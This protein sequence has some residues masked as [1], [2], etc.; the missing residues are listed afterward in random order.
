MPDNEPALQFAGPV[1]HWEA[2]PHA[3]D[4]RSGKARLRIEAVAED[5]LRVRFAPDGE[6]AARPSWDLLK[7]LEPTALRVREQGTVLRLAT[8]R[9]SAR[10]DLQTGAVGFL[11]ADGG[12]FARDLAG[13]CWREIRREELLGVAGVPDHELPAGPARTGLFLD[14]AMVRD[15]GYFGFG[16]RTGRLNRRHRRLTNWTV[17]IS[18]PGH[19][20]GHDNL[21]QAHPVFLAARPGHAWGLFLHSTWYS[22]FDVGA[23]REEVLRLFTLGGELD[24]YLFAGPTPAAVV[25]QLTRLTGRPTLPPLWS[26][27]Y[28]Q[29]RWS[30]ASDDEVQAI[31]EGFRRRDIPLDAIH[32]DIDYMRGFRVFTWDLERFP[33]PRSTVARLRAR[34]VRSV[35]IVDPGVKNDPGA[36]YVVA[37]EGLAQGHFVRNPDGTPFTGYVWP[38]EALFPDFCRNAT[39]HWWG[40]LHAGLVEMGVDGIWCDMNEP[41]IVDRPFRTP[42]VN[43]KPMP[44]AMMQGDEDEPVPHARA[45]NVYGSLMARATAEGLERLRPTA[46]PWVLTRSAYTGVQRHAV[47]WM[48]DNSSWWEH[49]QMSLPQ[50]LSMGLCGVPHAGVDIGGFYHN[51]YGELFARWMEMGTFYPFMRCHTRSG[52]RAQEPWGF[53]SGVERV[54][55]GAIELRYRLLPYLYTLAHEAHRSGAPILRPLFYEFPGHGEYYDL[56]D[57]FMVGPLLMAAPVCAPGVRRRLV[58]LPDGPWYDFWTGL[59]VGPGPIVHPA[60]LGRVPLFV[61]GGAILTLGNL[62]PST[63][64]PL[65]ELMLEIY[66]GADGQ[67]T[68]VE[69]DGESLAYA[70]GVLAETR[71][72]L[73]EVAP[74]RIEIELDER[75]GAFVPNARDLVVRVHLPDPPRDLWLD[76]GERRDWHWD[77]QQRCAELR[78]PDEG[79]PRRL[80]IELDV[81]IG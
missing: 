17:D 73:R 72:G 61:R 29:S 2:A 34:G 54:A 5:T 80:E 23:E 27:G 58:E 22:A 49:L 65:T 66:P 47:T 68:L 51:A 76:G 11:T 46:R 44:L 59:P 32:I 6:F 10:L 18:S 57:Q 33:D 37:E 50:L 20:R 15:E 74:D 9:L 7:E 48:G 38:G 45:H 36:D 35:V 75:R 56:E 13:P 19:S 24:Y 12:T 77:P 60:P 14:K 26:L 41:A 31:A 64:E 21:Y 62:R 53:G 71:F 55:R 3:V 40:D 25:E 81:E 79:V 16:Q 42:G 4:A 30:Y 70:D 78:W 67:W 8:G 43:D 63:S 52:S 28:H 1:T 69:D 39:R